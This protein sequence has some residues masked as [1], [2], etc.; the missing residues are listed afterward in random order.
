[1]EIL[2]F[3]KGFFIM[4]R[5]KE[6]DENMILDKAMNLFWCKGYNATSAQDLVDELGISRSSLYDTFGDKRKLFIVALKE[7]RKKMAGTMIEMI[8]KSTDAI[9]QIFLAATYEALEDKLKKGCFMVNSAIELVSTDN[10]VAEIVNGNMQD[11][12]NA[13]CRLIKK[14][15]DMGQFNTNNSAL[16]LARFL[17]NTIL[18][19]R[20]ASKSDKEK[21]VYD[22]IVK[23]ALSVLR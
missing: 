7:Y 14:G 8:E 22:D 6:F 4:A 9:K 19:I 21:K 2:I 23:V 10:E 5:T 16:S 13:L 1:V 12:E 17:F 15:Q 11:V 20:V 3:H 18:G